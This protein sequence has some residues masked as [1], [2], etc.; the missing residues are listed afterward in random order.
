ML[1]T[2]S[3]YPPQQPGYGYPQPPQSGPGFIQP[4][5]P[6]YG[7]EDPEVK[8]MEF[9]DESIRRGFIRKVYSILMV[10]QPHAALVHPNASSNYF[11]FC[12][13]FRYN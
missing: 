7:G 13:F 11:C 6:Q 4:P 9:N 5:Q 12:S 8:G 10:N 2:I 3:G 1:F